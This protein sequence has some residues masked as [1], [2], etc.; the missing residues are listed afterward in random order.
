[1]KLLIVNN[2]S[3]FVVDIVNIVKDLGIQFECI[4]YSEVQY[5]KLSSF[6]S[7]ILSGRKKYNKETNMQNNKIIEYCNIH[8]ISL[9]GICYGAEM[10]NLY[11]GGSLIKMKNV[12]NGL[13][14]VT[15]EKNNILIPKDASIY[16][17]QSH[18]Y[19]ICR[20]SSELELLGSSL[21]SKNEIF[22][23]KKKNIFGVQ[24]HPE[25]SG[26]DGRFILSNF[27]TQLN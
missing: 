27:F 8:N 10:I 4:L 23:H 26:K 9:L 21:E 24:F 3:P 17:Y 12:I 18:R 14:K 7:I 13:V 16:V 15:S 6:D 11:F 5:D 19:S 2:T 22:K 25:R 20:L 1:M